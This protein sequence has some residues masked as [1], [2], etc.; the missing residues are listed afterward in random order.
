MSQ[1]KIDRWGD[2]WRE[3]FGEGVMGAVA[4]EQSAFDRVVGRPNRPLVLFGAGGLGRKTLNALRLCSI[5]PNAFADSNPQLW[6]QTVDRLPVLSPADAAQRYGEDGTI[7]ITIWNHRATDRMPRRVEY[8]QSLGCRTVVTFLPLFWKFPELLL[9]HYPADLPHHVHEQATDVVAMS[10]YWSDDT[11][12]QEYL[13]QV[14]WRLHGD[15]AVLPDPVAGRTNFP[16]GLFLLSPSEVFV[17]CGAYDGDTVLSFLEESNKTFKRISAFEPDPA[18]FSQLQATISVL[19][20]RDRITLHQAATGAAEGRVRFSPDQGQASAV[21][22]GDLEVPCVA[23]DTALDGVVP[24][25][26]KMDIEGAELDALAGARRTI[27]RHMPIL[28]ISCYHRQDHLWKIPLLIRSY[29]P[30]YSFFL[31]PHGECWD[32]VCY[33]VPL[34]RLTA[35]QP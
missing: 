34:H 23:I 19:P 2:T 6:G 11:S 21:G 14:A 35:R 9:P 1:T 3:L 20:E 24:T 13:A 18:N 33:A 5:E 15:F 16:P 31:R 17:D 12:R 10:D 8:L 32:L 27:E 7:V 25:L 22:A 30:E 28:A 26:I 4:R 29:N